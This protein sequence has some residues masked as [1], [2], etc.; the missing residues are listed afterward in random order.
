MTGILEDPK[1]K[2]PQV[3]A[4]Q[5]ERPGY[6]DALTPAADYGE[7]TYKGSGKLLG[8]K[9]LITGADSGI[10]RAV[11]LAFAR[12][13]ADVVI[14]YLSEEEDARETERLVTSAGRQAV[15]ARGDI[16]SEAFCKDL[17]D[18]SVRQLG[19]LDILVNNA[20]YQATHESLQEFSTEE[21]DHTFRTNIYAMFWLCKYAEPHL[22][23]GSAVVNTA[24]INSYKPKSTLLAYATSKGAIATFTKALG[25]LWA[26]KGIR[27]NA[28]A[29]GPVWTPLIPSTMPEEQVAEFGKNTPLQRPGQPAELAS[30]YVLLASDDS[31][32]TTGQVYGVTGGTV[33]A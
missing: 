26:E 16:S 5:Q 25:E 31:T 17:I 21:W 19:G 27:V 22:K 23:P 1:T 9:A 3:K 6:S 33:L 29:P 32:Y 4:Q 13:G 28:V 7:N 12:E 24:S 11:A 15:L 10:G 2:Y 18:L 20:A 14:G 8:R 30:V